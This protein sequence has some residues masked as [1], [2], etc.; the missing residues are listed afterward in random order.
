MIRSEIATRASFDKIRY[1]QVWEDADILVAAL[2]PQPSDTVVS[3]GSAGDNCL[4]LLAEGAERVIAVDLN[5]AQLACIR[6]RKA[7]IGAFSHGEYLELMGSRAS[8][9]RGELLARAAARLD[10]TDQRFWAERKRAVTRHGL[11]GAGKFETYFRV[12]RRYA[13]PL[14]HSRSDLRAVLTPRSRT[15]RAAFYEDRWNTPRWRA[16][17]GTFF[18]RPMMGRLARDPEFFAY[19]EG[20]AAEHVAR[21]TFNALVEQDPSENPYL[22][23]ILTGRHGEVLPRP[24]REEC[25]EKARTRLDRL[26]L[27]LASIEALAD[28][29]LKADVFNLSDVFEYMSPQAHETAYARILSVARPGARIAYWNMMTPRRAPASVARRVH[30]RRDLEAAL[31]PRDKAFFYRDFVVEEA[32]G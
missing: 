28:E 32:I 1:A 4:A 19:A 2:R 23:W 21:K 12:L 29:G 27:R 7:A 10:A 5:P 8:V 9:R 14:T 25:F 17:L 13:L 15:E 18:C 26:E 20:G 6:M 3:I 11:G 16:L 31:K 30:A 22:H 24:L